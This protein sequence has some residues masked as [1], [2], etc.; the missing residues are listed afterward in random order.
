[1]QGQHHTRIQCACYAKEMFSSGYIGNHALWITADD[2]S[3]HFHYYDRL[4]VIESQVR[5]FEISSSFPVGVQRRA[6][7]PVDSKPFFHI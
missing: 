6:S 1:M 7:G 3:F 2:G 4:K 5:Y